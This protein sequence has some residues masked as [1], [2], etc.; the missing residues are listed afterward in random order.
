VTQLILV[1]LAV[2]WVAVLVPPFL[3]GRREGR[4]GDS[5]NSFRQQLNV[6]ERAA[7]ATR[8]AF[9]SSV[10]TRQAP[11]RVPPRSY[12]APATIASRRRARQ[13]RRQV[14]QVLVGCV[15]LTGALAATAGGVFFLVN[16]V[17]DVALVAYLGLL[18][19]MQRIAAVQYSALR[20]HR[21]AA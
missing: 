20:Y 6:L 10:M 2:V 1:V 21:S 18:I 15:L 4:P 7:P 19:Q 17:V 12:V 14:L 13:R 8:P 5:I 11:V 9:P 16:L 3:R